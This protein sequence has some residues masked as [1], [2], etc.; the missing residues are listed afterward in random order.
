MNSF[1]INV[2]KSDGKQSANLINISENDSINEG[3]EKF[4]NSIE[5]FIP[6]TPQKLIIESQIGSSGY[7]SAIQDDES[8]KEVDK[9]TKFKSIKVDEFKNEQK[10]K[11]KIA[12][13]KQKKYSTSVSSSDSKKCSLLCC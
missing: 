8:I 10:Q 4:K 1:E 7:D 3:K 13:K 11:E 12:L 2:D 5:Y 9:K 6:N